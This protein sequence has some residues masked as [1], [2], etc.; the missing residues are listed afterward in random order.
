MKFARFSRTIRSIVDQSKITWELFNVR[1]TFSFFTDKCAV[2]D[3][4]CNISRSN[5]KKGNGT[6][7]DPSFTVSQRIEIPLISMLKRRHCLSGANVQI[8]R[9]N[10]PA[11]WIPMKISPLI[12]SKATST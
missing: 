2:S 11:L 7:K 5:I 12:S 6:F 3:N 9:E 10:S 1:R 8:A 4:E